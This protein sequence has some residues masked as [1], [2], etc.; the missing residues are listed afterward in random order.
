M[1]VQHR[2]F[3]EQGFADQLTESTDPGPT[4]GTGCFYDPRAILVPIHVAALED[5]EAELPG[6]N[7]HR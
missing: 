7:R 5:L 3:G 1:D 2:S 6:C 4:A